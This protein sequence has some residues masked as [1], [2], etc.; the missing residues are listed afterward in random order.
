[1]PPPKTD[2]ERERW[3]DEIV[4]L[5][6]AAALRKVHVETLRAEIRAG[7]LKAIRLSPKKYGMTR[8]EAMSSSRGLPMPPRA[9]P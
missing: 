9:V 6:E 7:R 2:F 1:M 4:P 5:K 8:R 3:L